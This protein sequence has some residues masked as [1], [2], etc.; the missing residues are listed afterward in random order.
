VTEFEDAVWALENPMQISKP[1]TT[2]FGV[3]LIQLLEKDPEREMSADQ[4]ANARSTALSEWLQQIRVAA[5]TQ[6]S[7]FFSTDYVPGEIRRLQTPSAQ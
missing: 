2:T 7:R 3:H 6:I 5:E 1:V 4:I